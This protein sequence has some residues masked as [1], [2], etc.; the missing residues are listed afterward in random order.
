MIDSKM[1]LDEKWGFAAW[2]FLIVLTGWLAF[3]PML[4]NQY[5]IDDVP[6]VKDNPMIRPPNSL[7]GLFKSHYWQGNSIENENL[8]YRPITM[9]S[10]AL[11]IRTFGESPKAHHAINLVLHVLNALLVGVLVWTWWRR[12]LAGGIA[13]MVFLLQPIHFEA[14]SEIVG[15][16]ELLAA[17]FGMVTLLLLYWGHRESRWQIGASLLGG[18]SWLLALCSKESAILVMVPA[19]FLIF[20]CFQNSGN[21]TA[22]ARV[23]D[24][25]RSWR[26]T[27]FSLSF[28]LTVY[29][30][31]R[32]FVFR[33][34]K[35][36]KVAFS[37]NPVHEASLPGRLLMGMSIIGRSAWKMFWPYPL[38]SDYSFS[39]IPLTRTPFEAWFLLGAFFLFLGGWVICR[40]WQTASP[41][42]VGM[43]TWVSGCFFFSN[44]PIKI[45]VIFG[46]RL[47]Y[48]PSIGFCLVIGVLAGKW[49]ESDG[50]GVSPTVFRFVR[51][52]LLVAGG[53][54]GLTS[55]LFCRTVASE[56][57]DTLSTVQYS[58]SV[59][60]QRST[61]LWFALGNELY[62]AGKYDAAIPPFTR[63]VEIHPLD[64]AYYLLGVCYKNTGNDGKAIEVARRSV[65]LSP[66]WFPYR[67]TLSIFLFQSGKVDEAVREMEIALTYAPRD[68]AMLAS[69]AAMYSRQGRPDAAENAFR[70]ALAGD[71]PFP[72]IWKSF[73]D[74]L[75]K[76]GQDRRALGVYREYL[77]QPNGMPDR[78]DFEENVRRLEKKLALP[79]GK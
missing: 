56:Y 10:F 76:H 28:S 53:V 35:Q 16:A 65:D 73:A 7:A 57:R 64:E 1:K 47:M 4:E 55:I 34:V 22:R 17:S 74:F 67:K 27:I 32:F 58:L 3:G 31:A 26:W 29:L 51:L 71:A 24:L 38:Q 50:S 23:G 33:G 2:F 5:V 75:E 48:F 6:I 69:L 70:S 59:G 49:F 42:V 66:T 77:A 54:F 78:P 36:G 68:S 8:H 45:G 63:S 9:A 19:F 18:L 60:N 52:G 15:R 39:A 43:A 14:V 46:E 79:G 40:N 12:S 21:K 20:R 37:F 61:W 62:K 41:L 25:F 30:V 72:E 11:T 13:S 44:I